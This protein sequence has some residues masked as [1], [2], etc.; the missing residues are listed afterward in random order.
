L[1]AFWFVLGGLLVLSSALNAYQVVIVEETSVRVARAA[2]SLV[3]LLLAALAFRKGLA[4]SN[5]KPPRPGT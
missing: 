1:P 4:E 2:V 3:L 5:K